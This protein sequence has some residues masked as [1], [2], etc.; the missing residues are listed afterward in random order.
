MAVAAIPFIIMGVVA[1]MG[2]VASMQ[3]GEQEAK[4]NEFNARIQ[5]QNAAA[6]LDEGAAEEARRRRLGKLALAED[7]ANVGA[8]GLLA[9][10]S[11][12]DLQESNA[13]QLEI[14][15]L[16]AKREAQL[17]AR[18]FTVQSQLDTY[19]AGVSRTRGKM[20]AAQA[21]LGGAAK[22]ASYG[23]STNA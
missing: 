18:G 6:A 16:Q 4:A 11:P 5:E 2:A 19:S 23:M 12:L 10:G 9:E 20:G 17:R 7:R 15:A 1:A 21:L 3:Q 22:G 13:A 14:Y 8:S